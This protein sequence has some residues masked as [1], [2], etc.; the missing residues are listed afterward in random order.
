[1]LVVDDNRDAADTLALILELTGHAVRTAA[2]GP[3]GLRAA[4]EFRPDVV[5]LDIGMPG[6]DGYEVARRLRADLAVDGALL[7]ALTGYG[8]EADRRRS[9]AAGCDAHLVKPV[10]PDE[11]MTLIAAAPRRPGP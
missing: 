7:V 10:D 3:A 6:M 2:D 9:A 1:V 5:L 11:L 4:A 8:T